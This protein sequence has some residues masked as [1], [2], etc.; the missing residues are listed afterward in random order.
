VLFY[1]CS[2]NVACMPGAKSERLESGTR[3]KGKGTGSPFLPFVLRDRHSPFPSA[4][5]SA[6]FTQ[7]TENATVT[8][9]NDDGVI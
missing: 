5:L 8:G 6:S 7:A 9:R 4:G 2:E 3:G 1:V